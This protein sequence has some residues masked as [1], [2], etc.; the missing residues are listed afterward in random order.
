MAF[1]L[2]CRIPFRKTKA[3]NND[4]ILLAELIGRSPAGVARKLGNFG[5]FDPELR[6]RNVSGLA[7]S[8]KMD[9]AVWNEY[10]Q[11]WSKLV[12]EAEGLKEKYKDYVQVRDEQF[13]G[14]HVPIGPSEKEEI[15]KIRL[16]QSFFREAILSSYEH[17]CCVTGINLNEVLVARA[18]AII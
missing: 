13:L 2:Y 18:F 15:R 10:S 7:H 16:H 5:S 17:T 14:Q 4:V 6:K 3:N 11:D 9:E 1:D 8:S 12:I